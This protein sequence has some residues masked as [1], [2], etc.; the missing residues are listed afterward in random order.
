MFDTEED[1]SDLF[2]DI[3]QFLK[4]PKDEYKILSEEEVEILILS[5]INTR[6]EEGATEEEVFQVVKWA[7]T[8]RIGSTMLDL[9]LKGMADINWKNNDV[10]IAATEEARTYF[11]G[12]NL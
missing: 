10:T 2:E 7:E 8:Q 1:M 4:S 12:E 3:D 5:F 9:V 6:A 11:N